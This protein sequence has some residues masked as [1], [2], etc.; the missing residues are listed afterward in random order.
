M[1]RVSRAAFALALVSSSLG[2]ASAADVDVPSPLPLGAL[3]DAVRSRNP[4]IAERRRTH[5]AAERRPKAQ[6]WPDDPML[7]LEWWQQPIDFSTVPLMLTLKQPLTWPGKLRLRREV[8]EREARVVGDEVDEVERRILG[9]AKRAYFDLAQAE[10]SLDV[11]DSVRPL[12]QNLVSITDARYRVGKAVQA[13]LLKAQAELL[14]LDTERIDLV[15]ERNDAVA[16][17]NGLLDRAAEA[18]LGP[19]ALPDVT[20][21]PPASELLQAALDR[22]PEIRRARDEIAAAE[23]RLQ[24]ARRENVPDLAFWAAYM[25]NAP[26][27]SQSGQT[28]RGMDTFTVGVQT[29]LPVFS[30]P[31]KRALTGAA[32]AEL[33]AA[34]QSLAAARRK[35][36]VEVRAALV[37]LDAA[38]RHVQLHAKQLVPLSEVTLESALASYEANRIDFPAVLEAARAVRE[39]HLEHMRFLAEFA[40]RLADL[41]QLTGLD[42]RREGE[43]P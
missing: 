23:A 12:L 4:E 18:P 43:V 11:N 21:L 22:R 8:G 25:T 39:H 40:R 38:S 31:R 19:T 24:L 30:T 29:S 37:A 27:S 17:L 16:R 41:E 6:S 34:R 15:R 1:S 5:E 42:L 13:D 33:A 14:M 3:L 36:D 28:L 10:R 9:D 32:E 26:W 7:M 35:T 20:A 2:R